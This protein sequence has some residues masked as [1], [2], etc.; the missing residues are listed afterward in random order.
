MSQVGQ[1]RTED[2]IMTETAESV[3]GGSAPELV[4]R[5][6][7]DGHLLAVVGG[8]PVAVRVRQCFPWSD[9]WRHLS[10][11]NSEDRE[12]ALIEDPATLAPC[13][14][15]ALERALA[16]A[17]F[18]LEITRVCSIEEEVEIRHWTVETAQ[19]RRSFQTHLD[20]WP[21]TLPGGELLIRDVAG[22]LYRLA[23][24]RHM[25]R[26]SRQLLWAFVD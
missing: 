26:H 14:R 21:R 6:A 10:L 15:H 2:G 1:T 25:D 19:G 20:E 8:E 4:L 23:D 7:G 17:G 22:D 5:R 9:P 3:L 13:D 24:P 16:E 11:R 12:V 18:V